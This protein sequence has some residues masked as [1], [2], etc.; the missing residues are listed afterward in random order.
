M[1]GI[2]EVAKLLGITHRTLRY[3]EGQGLIAPQRRGATRLYARREIGRLRL[4]LRGKRL[5]FSIRDI[6]E[7][8][9]L[10][11][12]DPEHLEQAGRLHEKV[13]QRLRM[14]EAQREALEQTITELR[15][16]E[17]EAQGWIAARLK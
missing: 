17:R 13:C 12:V 3:Y 16:I 6:K 1:L 15:Q 14:L 8:L 2:Q 11:D 10:Y 5:G 4:I 7:F 9:D